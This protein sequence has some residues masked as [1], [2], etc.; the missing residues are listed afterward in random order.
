MLLVSLWIGGSGLKSF[1]LPNMS[2]TG[3]AVNTPSL[4]IFFHRK[5][6]ILRQALVINKEKDGIS[7]A[8]RIDWKPGVNGSVGKKRL[9]ASI[10]R[11]RE[12]RMKVR[13]LIQEPKPTA[14][15]LVRKVVTNSST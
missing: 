7:I 5:R 10:G 12:S 3:T 1:M 6:I 13:L 8:E 2:R 4:R 9:I 11:P 14:P 15:K